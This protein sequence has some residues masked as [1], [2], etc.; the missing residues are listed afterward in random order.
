MDIDLFL[1]T[2]DVHNDL[3]GIMNGVN[4]KIGMVVPQQGKISNRL[5][6]KK[7]RE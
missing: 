1:V 6:I 4:G 7:V 2:M 3:S 5:K